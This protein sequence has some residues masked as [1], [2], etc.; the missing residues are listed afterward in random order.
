MISSHGYGRVFSHHDAEIRACS[1]PVIRGIEARAVNQLPLVAAFAVAAWTGLGLR[2]F[3]TVLA[4][5]SSTFEA[6]T[7][8]CCPAAAQHF[9]QVPQR[10]PMLFRSDLLAARS[11]SSFYC[12]VLLLVGSQLASTIRPCSHFTLQCSPSFDSELSCLAQASAGA[13]SPRDPLSRTQACA[14]LLPNK[15]IAV[16]HAATCFSGPSS[17][18]SA[19]TEISKMSCQTTCPGLEGQVATTSRK[20]YACLT[21]AQ[22]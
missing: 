14:A 20:V 8:L 10:W 15:S 13:C 3:G 18:V 11:Y 7:S 1:S 6:L 19:V 9:A 21:H 16:E 5:A 2:P 12:W 4:R 17:E 22:S